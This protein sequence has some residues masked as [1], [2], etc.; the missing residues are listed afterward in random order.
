MTMQ[1]HLL[2]GRAYGFSGVRIHDLGASE[3]T[4]ATIVAD[5]SGSV[6][7]FATDIERCIR[8]VVRACRH[9]QRA[10]NLMLRLL[11][12]DH[13]LREIHGFKPLAA[14]CDADYDGCIQIRGSTALYDASTHAVEALGAYGKH[15]SDHDFDVNAIAFV[16]T[17]G[18]DN[19]SSASVGDLR[20]AM[21]GVRGSEALESLV[22]ILVGV[23]IQDAAV[24]KHLSEL[25][26]NGGFDAYVELASADAATLAKLASFVSRSI[27]VQS[28]ALGSGSSRSL[29]F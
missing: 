13:E 21:A 9:S 4:L 12:F 27:S 3:Y 17:D 26:H 18:M 22:A 14:S 5:V 29:S 25:Q 1:E 7:A 20:K 15:L 11:A 2:T 16:I 28:L 23:N 8:D 10:D 6:G 19:A 24:A